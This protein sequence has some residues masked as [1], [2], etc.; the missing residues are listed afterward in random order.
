M[1][2]NKTY[3]IFISH[4]WKYDSHY[5]TIVEF[6]N[7]DGRKLSW[8]DYSVPIDDPIHTNGTEADLREKI[9]SK[10]RMSSVVILLGGVYASYSE[11]IDVEIEIAQSYKKPIITIELRGAERSSDKAI[12]SATEVVGWNADSIIKAVKKHG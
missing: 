4:S 11:W 1:S 2:N 9:D 3:N 5:S 7:S 10:I 6:L 8:R 12:S